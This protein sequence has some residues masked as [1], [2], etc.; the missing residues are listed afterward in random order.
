MSTLDSTPPPRNASFQELGDL[1]GSQRRGLASLPF[2]GGLKEKCLFRC[3]I[4][5]DTPALELSCAKR[6]GGVARRFEGPS[7]DAALCVKTGPAKLWRN[8]ES[9]L[10]PSRWLVSRRG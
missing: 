3:H 9:M 1:R 2:F 4:S 10:H 5:F 6:T 7:P 8:S